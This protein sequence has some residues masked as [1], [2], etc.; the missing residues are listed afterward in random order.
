MKLLQNAY[1]SIQKD[2][3]ILS[4]IHLP[5]QTGVRERQSYMFT[6]ILPIKPGIN[7]KTSS[8]QDLRN[9]SLNVLSSR[10]TMIDNY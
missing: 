3:C 10:I 7:N 1:H 6:L 5:Y 8:D 2:P 9:N 4:R